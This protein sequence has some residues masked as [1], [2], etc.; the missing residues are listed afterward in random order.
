MEYEIDEEL[1]GIC[2]D[3]LDDNRTIAE[4][5]ELEASDWF[6]TAHYCGGFD[7]TDKHFAF[8]VEVS[9]RDYCFSLTLEEAI[10]IAGGQITSPGTENENE[11]SGF[12]VRR[13]TT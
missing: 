2:R 1:R 4:W 13:V 10:S 11:I 9:G 6:Q 12:G 8:T 7:A 3:I 5:A